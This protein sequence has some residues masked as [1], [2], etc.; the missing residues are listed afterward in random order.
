[1]EADQDAAPVEERLDNITVIAPLPADL[2]AAELEQPSNRA[3][4]NPAEAP[5]SLA[6]LEALAGDPVKDAACGW[7]T[8]RQLVRLGSLGVQQHHPA[9]TGP[10]SFNTTTFDIQMNQQNCKQTI[11]RPAHKRHSPELRLSLGHGW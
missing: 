1:V 6:G 5:Q 2:P 4:R 7:G 11:D 3:L 8:T 9:L 10:G